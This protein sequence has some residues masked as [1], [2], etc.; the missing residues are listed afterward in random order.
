MGH[1]ALRQ[2]RVDKDVTSGDEASHLPN[3]W[4][5]GP[6]PA[7]SDKD[8]SGVGGQAG[9]AD[10]GGTSVLSPQWLLSGVVSI[11]IRK[12]D[13]D[14]ST[15]QFCRDRLPDHWT[16]EWAVDQDDGFRAGHG[17]AAVISRRWP[18]ASTC[19]VSLR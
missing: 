14:V 10:R 1:V 18:G 9:D 7:V 16:Y 17:Q 4:K 2:A 3:R 6:S 13:A 5:Q 15:S 19:T 11:Q 12:H 8:V